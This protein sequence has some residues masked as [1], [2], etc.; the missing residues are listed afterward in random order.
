MTLAQQ[1]QAALS[2][3]RDSIAAD[4]PEI[5]EYLPEQSDQEKTFDAN[6]SAS[7]Q[8]TELADIS[9][10]ERRQ[11]LEELRAVTALPPG[12]FD[13]TGAQEL[14]TRL[15][16]L[17]HRSV[18]FSIDEQQLSY[19]HGSIQALPPS[20]G[21]LQ[22]IWPANPIISQE[23]SLT[24]SAQQWAVTVT[25]RDLSPLLGS[26]WQRP[27]FLY[28]SVLLIN[29]MTMKAVAGQVTGIL[30]DRLN[31]YQFGAAPAVMAT[32]GFWSPGVRGRGIVC[33]SGEAIANGTVINLNSPTQN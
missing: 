3:T 13:R 32:G 23:Q 29:P 9:Q 27:W 15:R 22:P 26:N 24:A 18:S 20:E 2:Q 11:L 4:W 14:A 33:F 10:E 12:C 31:R 17:L 28:R 8:T 16:Y 30:T 21:N 7:E 6:H 19:A 1:L 25:P 5:I